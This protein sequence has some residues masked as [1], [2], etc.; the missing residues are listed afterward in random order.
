MTYTKRIL[1]PVDFSSHS[2][3]AARLAANIARHG[4]SRLCLFHTV[5]IPDYASLP[6]HLRDAQLTSSSEESNARLEQLKSELAEIA[7]SSAIETLTRAD[8]PRNAILHYASEWNA[9]LIIMGT[10]GKSVRDRQ[11]LGS[12]AA[13][14]TRDAQVPVLVVRQ[15]HRDQL[16][17]GSLFQ[18]PIVAVDFSRFVVPAIRAAAAITTPKKT[19]EL[20]HVFFVPG[21]WKNQA[22]LSEALMA[23]R[24]EE[25][26]KLEELAQQVDAIPLAVHVRSEGE[27]VSDQI[28]DYIEQSKTDLLVLGAHS[29]DKSIAILGTVADRLLR[30]SKVPVLVIPDRAIS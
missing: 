20:L 14:I 10:L 11:G 26:K 4:E 21:E 28:Q 13:T 5:P 12:V 19:I 24:T 30:T 18:N 25:L 16:L 3:V 6:V 23:A 27:H 22:E 8:N 2:M 1:V 9:S 17:T 15:D 29:R 7:G